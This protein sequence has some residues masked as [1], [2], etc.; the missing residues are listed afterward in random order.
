MLQTNSRRFDPIL[1]AP[2]PAPAPTPTFA[3]AIALG[4]ALAFGPLAA[5][6]LPAQT[7]EPDLREVYRELETIEREIEQVLLEESY[8]GTHLRGMERDIER[9]EEKFSELEAV[10]AQTNRTLRDVSDRSSE[11]LDR[12]ETSIADERE[13]LGESR[14]ALRLAS[15]L[16]LYQAERSG[17]DDP[18][19]LALAY[20]L[21]DRDFSVRNA[22]EQILELEARREVRREGRSR[23]ASIKR[24][25]GVAGNERLDELRRSHARLVAQLDSMSG[26][27]RSA[28]GRVADLTGRQR[29]L[30]LLLAR[31]DLSSSQNRTVEPP[32]LTPQSLRRPALP[33]LSQTADVSSRPDDAPW[34]RET[35]VPAIDIP[36]PPSLDGEAT[37]APDRELY[38]DPARASWVS[39]RGPVYA[40]APGRVLYAAPFAGYAHVLI[41]DHGEGWA[42]VYGNLTRCDVAEGQSVAAGS[43]LGAYEPR[44]IAPDEPLWLEVRHDTDTVDI[45]NLPGAGEMWSDRLFGLTAKSP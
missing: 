19:A 13:T 44:E 16:L 14:S 29:E 7:P 11:A 36:D 3:I 22:T 23:L 2:A 31:L 28:Q 8:R 10:D 33:G 41:L 4:L 1:P 40:L 30:K 5:D 24:R 26:R 21:S 38:V 6:P 25:R 32:E 39:R 35:D 27:A 18:R 17:H 42:S 45:E 37:R 43:P 12:I 9:S 34:P 15:V 20:A